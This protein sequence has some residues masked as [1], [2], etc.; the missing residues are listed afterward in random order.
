MWKLCKTVKIPHF[1]RRLRKNK[2]FLLFDCLSITFLLWCCI[3]GHGGGLYQKQKLQNEW[4]QCSF[5]FFKAV[6]WARLKSVVGRL[7]YFDT[8]GLFNVL[9]A[10]PRVLF[11]SPGI[12]WVLFLNF[13]EQPKSPSLIRPDDVRKMLAPDG[14]E[15][16]QEDEETVADQIK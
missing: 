11:T 10:V 5:T 6:Q 7:S 3:D 4:K 16:K 15:N 8:A 1:Y 9:P 2:N 13:T 12:V 14:D